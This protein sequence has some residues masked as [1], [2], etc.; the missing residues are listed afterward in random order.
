[1]L[2]DKEHRKSQNT[3]D[4]FFMTNLVNNVQVKIPWTSISNM[5]LAYI[6]LKIIKTYLST[7]ELLWTRTTAY[8]HIKN[9]KNKKKIK[10]QLHGRV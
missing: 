7:S 5:F 8:N 4:F 6:I 10:R 2:C 1:M 3:F 9:R